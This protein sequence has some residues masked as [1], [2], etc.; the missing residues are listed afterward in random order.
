MQSVSDET[1]T[2]LLTNLA[3]GIMRI[4][5]NKPEAANAISMDQRERIIALLQEG[6]NNPDVRV[7]VIAANGRHFCSGA[8]VRGM[9]SKMAGERLP[10]STIRTMMQGAQRLIAA[11]LDCGKPV[12]AAVQGPAA[13]MG[14]HLALASD[15]I[16]ATENAWFS[17][18]FVLR[19]LSLDAAGAYLLPRRLGLQKAKE[20]AFLGDKVTAAEAKTLGL[21]NIVATE[22]ELAG[23]V[24][25]LATRLANSATMAI[26][27]T[28]RLLNGSLD[29]DR[30]SAF[31]AEAMAQEICGSTHDIKEG[32]TS[33]LEKRPS[34]FKGH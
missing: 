20:M 8:D 33:F 12:I 27:L 3:D 15:M 30:N 14:C 1:D 34:N 25:K 22:A 29:Q 10:G 28:K 32:V 23:E 4:T 31:L 11:V 18:P 5:L 21:V 16:V 26:S 19:G 17:Q 2:T 9:A 24:D 7:I 6:D 13:G